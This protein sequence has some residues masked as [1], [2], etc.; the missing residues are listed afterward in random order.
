MPSSPPAPI[1]TLASM[2]LSV[3]SHVDGSAVSLV[4]QVQLWSHS[5]K[6]PCGQTHAISSKPQSNWLI[7]VSC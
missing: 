3:G 5:T 4:Q 2:C 1:H 7:P 6:L